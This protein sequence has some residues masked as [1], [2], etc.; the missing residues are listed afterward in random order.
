MT[1]YHCTVWVWQHVNWFGSSSLSTH[2]VLDHVCRCCR[3][4]G[5]VFFLWRSGGETIW[6]GAKSFTRSSESHKNNFQGNR[7]RSELFNLSIVFMCKVSLLLFSFFIRLPVMIGAQMDLSC[8]V[9]LLV[10]CA[11]NKVSELCSCSPEIC[12]FWLNIHPK[13]KHL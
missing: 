11:L 4:S 5:S 9:F 8:F 7:S 1:G 13:E 3:D 2:R 12:C 6:D 10:L